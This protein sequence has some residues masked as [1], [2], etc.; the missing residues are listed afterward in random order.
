M[1]NAK[2]RR[3]WGTVT[4]GLWMANLQIT[5]HGS[6]RSSEMDKGLYLAFPKYFYTQKGLLTNERKD[7]LKAY[8]VISLDTSDLRD[9]SCFACIGISSTW[10]GVR[11]TRKKGR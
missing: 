11:L 8:E 5:I 3:M 10:E 2:L 6:M 1:E 9:R 4:V 7:T